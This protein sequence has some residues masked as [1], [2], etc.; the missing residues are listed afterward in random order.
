MLTFVKRNIAAVIVAATVMG[1]GAVAWA[2]ETPDPTVGGP[3]VSEAQEAPNVPDGDRPHPG[4]MGR[5]GRR[6]HGP[7]PMGRAVHGDLI[8][9]T[10]DGTF[11]NVTFD[12]GQ[13]VSHDGG[14]IVLKRPDSDTN[15]TIT[16]TDDTRYRGVE[17]ASEIRDG[18]RAVVVSKDG[19]A[20]S[21]GQRPERDQEDR[22]KADAS[23]AT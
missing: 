7:G 19:K 18:E 3:A 23:P 15:V 20:V 2:Q 10:K 5:M 9:R 12:K 1:L 16:L 13:V 8:V 22:A 17:N 21:V 6:H 4:P 11:E 14:K